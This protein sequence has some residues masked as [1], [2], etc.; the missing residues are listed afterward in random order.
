[1][2]NYSDIEDHR[3]LTGKYAGKPWV[4]GKNLKLFHT[5]QHYRLV[6]KEIGRN[7]S[8]FDDFRQVL[9]AMREALKVRTINELKY[10]STEHF[11][12]PSGGVRKWAP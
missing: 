6:L 9:I 5:L 12:S 7:L 11:C 2:H 4:C 8:S 3:T 1:M 10:S